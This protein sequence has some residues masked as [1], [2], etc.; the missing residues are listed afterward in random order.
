MAF[1]KILEYIFSVIGF[2][3]PSEKELRAAT[4]RILGKLQFT[5]FTDLHLHSKDACDSDNAAPRVCAR[6]KEL[7]ATAVALTQHGVAGQVYL[8]KKECKK[9]G[10][11]FIPGIEVYFRS[12]DEKTGLKHLLLLALNDIGWKVICMAISSTQNKDGLSVMTEDDLWRFF[13]PGSEGHGNVIATTACVSGIVAEVLLTNHRIEKE[14]EKK[15][16]RLPK[17]ENSFEELKLQLETAEKKY[18]QARAAYEEA[19][20]LSAMKFTAKEKALK[21]LSGKEAETAEKELAKEKELTLKAALI[22]DS[23]KKNADILKKELV[24]AQKEYRAVEEIRQRKEAIFEMR[25][26]ELPAKDL[27]QKAVEAM[28][29]LREIFG[30]DCFFAEVQYHGIDIEGYVYPAVAMIARKLGVPIVATNDVHIVDNSEEELLRRRM[31]R[32]LRF[33]KWSED[34]E[35]DAELYIKTNEELVTSL[36]QILPEDIV[37]EA[38]QNTQRITEMCNVEFQVKNHYPKFISKDGRSSEEIFDEL[39][40]KG[41]KARFP[42]GFSS[43]YR[44]RIEAEKAVMKKMGYVDYHLI[45]RDFM[46]YAAKHDVIPPELIAQA[47]IEEEELDRWCQERGFTVK[48]GMSAGNGRGSAVGSLVC[49]LLFITGLDPILYKL[50]F[51]RF[52]NPERVSMP[53]IDSDISR[54]VRPRVIEYVKQKYGADCVAGITTQNSQAPKGAIRIAAKCYGLWLNKDNPKDNGE[55]MFLSLGDQIAK[56]VPDDVGTTFAS[57]MDGTTVFEALTQKNAD[58][59]HAVEIIRWAKAFEGCFT[60]Y[61]AHAAGIVITD[62]TPIK[63]IVPLR[64][65][66]KLGIYTTQCDMVEVE[67]NGML[68]FDFLGLKTLDIISDCLWMLKKR[69]INLRIADIPLDDPKVFREILAK[70]RTNSVFQL[71]SD[72]MKKMLIKFGPERFEHLIILVS[73]FRPGPIQYLND[74]I[75]VKNGRKKM[76]FMHPKLELI[77]GSTYGAII[78]QEQVM[79][80]FQ[81]LAG[82][83]LGGADLVRRA[84][85]K[86]K[87]AVLEKERQAFVYGDPER[88]D[89][90]G[91]PTPIKGCV[92]NGIDEKIANKLFDQMIEFAK[93]AFN[94]AH[95]AVY[96]FNAY[97]TAYLKYYFPAEFLTAAMNWAEKTQKKDPIPGLMAEAKAMGVEVCAPDIN[98]SGARFTTDGKKIFFGLSAV[99]TVGASA[100]EIL[101]ER[102]KN[103]KFKSFPDFYLRCR[104]KKNAVENLIYAGAFDSFTKSRTALVESIETYKKAADDVAAQE[105]FLATAKAMLPVIDTITSKEELASRQDEMNLRRELTSVTT[106]KKLQKRIE[107]REAALKKA[108]ETFSGISV[109][110]DI[111]EW[112]KDR[113]EKEHE[114][115]GAYVTGHPLDDYPSFDIPPLADISDDTEQVFGVITAM[116]IKKR[117][118]DGREMAFVTLEDR[119]GTVKVNFFVEQY[120]RE[121]KKIALGNVLV[122]YGETKENDF[123]VGTEEQAEKSV[124]YEFIAEKAA[125]VDEGKDTYTI[126]VPCYQTFYCSG[127]EYLLRE[128]CQ[129]RFGSRVVIHDQMRGINKELSFRVGPEIEQLFRCS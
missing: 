63:E 104:T 16:K 18:E 113:L 86:K 75:D 89:V 27:L 107:D 55:K 36:L 45:V 72:G 84:M 65:N 80:I 19:K 54:T 106:S 121:K 83:T 95:G 25:K 58:N 115:L 77:L 79:Q 2:K 100:D 102:E 82:Y 120:K 91:N 24:K 73:T 41:V 68:K 111:A 9:R 64:W 1:A 4:K 66:E 47:P 51:E 33:K 52:L 119:T 62:G 108:Q 21:K 97:I 15:L 60:S 8:F 93:Y 3:K 26:E 50:Y 39:I 88:K 87:L 12:G 101:A 70:G 67:E 57:E 10:L 69:G 11:K 30:G 56:Q 7:G 61:G 43:G 5:K 125:L 110:D 31:L 29:N 116:D 42:R 105:S 78:Y 59:R 112:K 128:K 14:I 32:T 22:K 28:T 103:G 122:L 20:K 17:E 129:K 85:S 46:R 114:L 37:L 48:V 99:K 53:D 38:M 96:A 35:G 76:T 117:K 123:S 74:I 49:D 118:K 124:E 44:E 92:N 98:I 13:G 71:E 126:D 23:L 34:N 81:E 6:E 40:E 127:K 109:R 90:H 94:K